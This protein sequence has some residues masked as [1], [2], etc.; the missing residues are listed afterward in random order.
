MRLPPE[1]DFSQTSE[2]WER[3]VFDNAISFAVVLHQGCGQRE[4]EQYRTLPAAIRRA[5][6]WRGS[7]GRTP[8]VYAIAASGRYI[9]LDRADWPKWLARWR[10]RS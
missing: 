3:T 9:C 6:R 2:N 10:K 1:H 8:A 5:K 4:R 7:Y